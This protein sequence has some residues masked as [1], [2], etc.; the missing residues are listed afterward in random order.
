MARA[1]E[2]DWDEANTRHIARHGVTPREVEE[3]FANDPLVVLT[4]QWRSGEQRILCAG[5]TA[6]G[7]PLQFVYTLRQGKIRVITAHTAK[8]KL[9]RL[10]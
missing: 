9:R 10:L 5:L 7:R 1:A 2:F 3:A 8:R 6:A 4:T